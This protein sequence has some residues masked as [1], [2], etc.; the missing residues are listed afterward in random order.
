MGVGDDQL[1]PGQAAGLQGAEEVG[2][3]R[4]GF[5]VADVESKDLAAPVSGDA[6]R[7]HARL[8]HDPPADSGF[9]VG[10]IDEHIRIGHLIER[11]LSERGDVGVEVGADP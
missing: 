9:A 4:F 11:A 10:R 3:E 6:D 7:D 1:D 8:G 2:P 5:G